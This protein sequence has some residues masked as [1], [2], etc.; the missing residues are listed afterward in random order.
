MSSRCKA[1]RGGQMVRESPKQL[2][3]LHVHFT[4]LVSTGMDTP[5]L[6]IRSIIAVYIIVIP[7]LP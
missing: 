6:T 1:R 7:R 3:C 5:K 2:Y 4:G